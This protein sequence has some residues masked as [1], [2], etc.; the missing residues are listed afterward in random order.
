LGMPNMGGGGGSNPWANPPDTQ[1]L[2]ATLQMM[3]NPMMQQ[4]MQQFMSD[5]EA[6]RQMM[7]SNPMMR[8]L[9]ETNPQAAAMM[10]NPE[11]VS[12]RLSGC[13]CIFI[14]PFSLSSITDKFCFQRHR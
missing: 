12:F 10:S 7:E 1:Q 4:M 14:M 9:R 3:E 6:L 2:E 8:Q 13:L 11:V 5:P